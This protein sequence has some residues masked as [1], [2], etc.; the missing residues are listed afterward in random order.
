M[1]AVGDRLSLCLITGTLP[2]FAQELFLTAQT[3]FDLGHEVLRQPQV[4]EGLLEGFSGLLRLTA[5]TC[6]AL[7]RCAAATLSV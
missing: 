5:I 7:L 2:H 6:E 1:S 4:I 3:P